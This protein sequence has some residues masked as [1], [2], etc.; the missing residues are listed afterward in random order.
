MLR[1]VKSLKVI[2]KKKNNKHRYKP[3]L[4]SFYLTSRIKDVHDNLL[5]P[6]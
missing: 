3:K 1:L 6:F 5:T 2:H 4:P